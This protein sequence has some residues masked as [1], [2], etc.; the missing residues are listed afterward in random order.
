L[1]EVAVLVSSLDRIPS[2]SA[3][4]RA[5]RNSSRPHPNP[6]KYAVLHDR[7][8]GVARAAR[9][10]AAARWKPC[11]N[12]S[13]EVN[14][15]NGETLHARGSVAGL[16]KSFPR[17]RQ[18]V[19]AARSCALDATLAAART[20]IKRS[21]PGFTAGARS[22]AITLSRRRIRLR[23]TAPPIFLLA[24]IPMRSAGTVVSRA[25]KRMPRSGE[26]TPGA[27]ASAVKSAAVRI[28]SKPAGRECAGPLRR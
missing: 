8:F 7:L 14:K 24:A 23:T 16:A 2:A 17:R 15:G 10:K 6:L 28:M 26:L 18:S 22:R 27:A 1:E 20:P 11:K 9:L 12:D 13:V 4:R 3:E 21:V 5:A 25:T 19:S